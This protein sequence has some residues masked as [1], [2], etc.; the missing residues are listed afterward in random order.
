MSYLIDLSLE[1]TL[2]HKTA[3]PMKDRREK[4]CLLH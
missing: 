2:E 3:D 1:Y 4:W